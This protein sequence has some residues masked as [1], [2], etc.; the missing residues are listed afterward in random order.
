MLTCLIVPSKHNCWPSKRYQHISTDSGEVCES[1][2]RCCV[3]HALTVLRLVDEGQSLTH[4]L[5]GE[6]ISKH[7]QTAERDHPSCNGMIQSNEIDFAIFLEFDSTKLWYQ[8]FGLLFVLSN[9]MSQIVT[10]CVTLNLCIT[11]PGY[12]PCGMLN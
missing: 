12:P 2:A 1:Q 5:Q 6:A 7:L 9:Y 11:H 10:S 4:Q 8:L 3:P